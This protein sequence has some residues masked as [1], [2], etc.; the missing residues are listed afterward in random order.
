MKIILASIGKSHERD[1]KVLIEDYTSRVSHYMP[2]DWIINQKEEMLLKQIKKEDYVILLDE[3]GKQL[4]STDLA[5]KIESIQNQSY[6]KL[7]FV[8]GGAF[9]AT[10]DLA[11]R[12][13]LVLSFS[14]FVFPHM[15][16][17]VIL[18]EQI[19]RAFTIIKGEKY[20]HE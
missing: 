4:S 3:R 7:Y 10:K 2:C 8:I 14:K 15:L 11:D 1:C 12:A 20:H 6:K 9:G 16:M 18:A 19:Y 5:T 13:D 17:R